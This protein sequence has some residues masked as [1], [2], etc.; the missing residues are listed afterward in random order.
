[1]KQPLLRPILKKLHQFPIL[2]SF[3][4]KPLKFINGKII[5]PLIMKG[6]KYI[7]YFLTLNYYF[8]IINIVY[9]VR[10]EHLS[11]HNESA[12]QNH[13]DR[14]DKKSELETIRLQL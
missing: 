8:R 11:L 4:P 3:L 13:A 9:F 14:K 5:S 7:F 2:L 6:L 10:A 1:M 12:H